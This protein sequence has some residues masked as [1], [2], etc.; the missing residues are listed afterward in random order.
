MEEIFERLKKSVVDMDIDAAKMAAQDA[1]DAGID[2][3]EA[4]IDGLAKGMEQVSQL[5]DDGD[6]FVPEV[7]C[8]ADT[9]YAGLDVLKPHVKRSEAGK[10]KKVVIGVVEGDTHDIGKNLVVMMLEAADFEVFDLG[11]NVPLNAFVDKVLEV[12]A[13]I[14]GMSALMTTT[15]EGMKVV[16]EDVKA[17]AAD[18]W[19]PVMVGGAAVSQSFADQVGADG[20]ASNA[21]EAVLVARRL[22]SKEVVSSEVN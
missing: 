22:A 9:M 5:Y 8:C 18:R 21:I 15:R 19:R 11:R 17:R 16:I 2:A 4:I 14:V 20:Y 13:D 12:D 6:Y 1:L 7:V 10:K 3:Y